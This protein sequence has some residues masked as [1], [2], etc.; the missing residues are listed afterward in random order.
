MTMVHRIFGGSPLAVILRLA[1]VS[2][3]V[4][5]AMAWLDI[6]PLSVI[7]SLERVAEHL[8]LTGFV[9]LR[10]LGH[11][12]L[13]GAAIVVPVWILLRI[14]SFRTPQPREPA[15]WPTMPGQPLRGDDKVRTGTID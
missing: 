12:L 2:I 10:Q 5:A 7:A 11:Y 3:L 8:W 6:D 15:R 13:A 1:F 9:E 14:F 4:G